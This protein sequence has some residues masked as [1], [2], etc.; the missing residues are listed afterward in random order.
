MKHVKL[1]ESFLNE[2]KSIDRDEMISWIEKTMR[3]VGTSEE[4]N[5]SPGGIW[6]CGECG[7]K[8]K[9]QRIYDYYSDN[10]SKY[11]LG[12]LIKWEEEL[13]KRG[14]YSDWYDA[15]TVMIRPN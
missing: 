11:N 15:G 8:Y 12:V 10:Y 6:L 14:W 2:T 9:G 1:F 4:F 7:D 3:V 13:N 5:D